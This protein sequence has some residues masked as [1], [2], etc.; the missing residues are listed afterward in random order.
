M[1]VAKA[2]PKAGASVAL[3]LSATRAKL[4]VTRLSADVTVTANQGQSPTGTIDV[5]IDGRRNSTTALRPGTQ[6]I[7]LPVF[8]STGKHKVQV[9]YSGDSRVSSASSPTI[10]VTVSK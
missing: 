6:R 9:R 3:V 8:R 5:Y 1:S 4:K 2:V 7:T 10:T